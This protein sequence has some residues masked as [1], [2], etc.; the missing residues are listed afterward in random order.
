MPSTRLVLVKWHDTVVATQTLAGR[1]EPE[2]SFLPADARG[3]TIE[4][5]EIAGDRA[6]ARRLRSGVDGRSLFSQVAS[7]AAHPA[8]LGLLLS[9]K[10]ASPEM[11]ENERAAALGSFMAR[12]GTSE[13]A[14]PRDLEHHAAV[15]EP[16]TD[17]PAVPPS[18]PATTASHP[19]PAQQPMKGGLDLASSSPAVC[20]PSH[21]AQA[22]GPM[23]SRNVIVGALTRS[24]P[25]C[26][27]D[28][29]IRDGQV[30]TLTFPCVGDG[31]ATLRVG[32]STFEGAVVGGDV[33][34][35]TG[36]QFAWIDGCT[37]TSAQQVSGTLAKGTLEF[38]YGEAPRAEQHGC[39]TAC[40]A[41]GTLSVEVSDRP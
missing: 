39:A 3:V 33:R 5:H 36:T 21:V 10:G 12:I 6:Y 22:T 30:G 40:R 23:C 14:G 35:C 26:F 17:T 11:L 20:I 1:T 8:I 7:V 41:T 31:E 9:A 19:A 32:S 15:D 24:T 18:P 34:V 28:N 16:P 13:D 27:T 4:V 29:V 2:L 38:G 37:W 25:A